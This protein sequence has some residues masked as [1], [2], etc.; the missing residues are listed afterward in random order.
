MLKVVCTRIIALLVLPGI[1]MAARGCYAIGERDPVATITFSDGGRI[2]VKLYP[3]YAP[4]T[5]ANFISLANS[6]F[7]ENSPVHRIE[8][9]FVIQMGMSASGNDLDYTIAGEFPDNGY[10]SNELTHDFGTI[11]MAR[12]VGDPDSKE[13]R[14]SASSQ[15]FI[16]TTNQ[17][18]L[19]GS[20][21]AFGKIYEE[22]G[23][24]E[25][26][27]ISRMDVNSNGEPRDEIYIVSVEVNT[28]GKDYGEPE[29][30]ID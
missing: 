14:D 29:K 1:L 25:L 21:A 16:C 23:F 15:F 18:A 3:E 26:V 27:K 28:Y 8:E 7:Y 30:I 6:G 22:S 4:N 17:P 13:Y 2:K 11:S 9:Y 20:Y 19:N 24:D 12:R 10:K 5:V